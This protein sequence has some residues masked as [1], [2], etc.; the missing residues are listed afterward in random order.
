MDLYSNN[1]IDE[2][3]LKLKEFINSLEKDGFYKLE[4]G[5]YTNGYIT[6]EYPINKYIL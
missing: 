4:N 1:K 2:N 5:G 3:S 6:F